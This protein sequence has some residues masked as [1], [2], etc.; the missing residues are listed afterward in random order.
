MKIGKQGPKQ[1]SDVTRSVLFA[2][3]FWLLYGEQIRSVE[4]WM[5]KAPFQIGQV[6]IVSII[7]VEWV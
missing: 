1:G 2:R 4:E 7:H 5:W 6:D 3:S